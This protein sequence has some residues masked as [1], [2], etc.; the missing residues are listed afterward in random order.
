VIFACLGYR[1]EGGQV[2]NSRLAL[3]KRRAGPNGEEFPFRGRVVDMGVNPKTGKTETT[4]VIDWGDAGQSTAPK[5]DDWGR[6]RGV[7]LLRRIIMSLLVDCGEPV[8][9]FANG[10]LV[11]ALKV[12]LVE[13]EFFKSY[14]TT[15]ETDADK[16]AAKRVAF[17]RAIEQAGDKIVTREIGGVDYIWLAQAGPAD[18]M[19]PGPAAQTDPP[20]SA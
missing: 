15:G 16:K 5:K 18:K 9:P 10:P 17:K 14:V 6:G 12:T 11:R 13:A 7:K 19:G 20:E 1:G 8:V 3:R 2:G 4:L